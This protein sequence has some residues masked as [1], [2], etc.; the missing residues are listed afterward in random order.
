MT[1]LTDEVIR[2]GMR[3]IAESLQKGFEEFSNV[4]KLG[5]S[6]EKTRSNDCGLTRDRSG[7][8]T[9]SARCHY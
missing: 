9:I 8:S 3:E 6:E 1:G 7:L 5:L 4:L 2:T